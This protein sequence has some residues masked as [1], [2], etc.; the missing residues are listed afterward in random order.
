MPIRF[1]ISHSYLVRNDDA[2]AFNFL[3]VIINFEDNENGGN[4]IST[5][6]EISLQCLIG[7][8]QSVILFANKNFTFAKC[9]SRFLLIFRP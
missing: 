5:V 8:T 6:G 3:R 9:S 2:K 7:I 4:V 1:E